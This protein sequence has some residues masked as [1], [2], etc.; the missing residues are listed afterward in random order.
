MKK[1]KVSIL[2]L[3]ILLLVGC[4]SVKES[5]D[6]ATLQS[7]L[8]ENK[9][10]VYDATSQVGYATSALYATRGDI[11]V[12]FVKATKKYDVQG[13]FLDESRNIY[14][15]VGADYKHES[16]GGKNW[17]YLVVT[18]ETDYYFVGWIDDS[19]ITVSAPID[20][21]KRMNNI[22]KELGYK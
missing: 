12:N 13:V 17:T 18:N 19:Y 9:F 5:V 14:S 4:G 8:R 6:P 16:N 7:I 10:E 3:S 20:Q 15:V 22:V 2:I 1:L 11:K 21:Q